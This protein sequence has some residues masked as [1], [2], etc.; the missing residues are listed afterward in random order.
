MGYVGTYTT[1]VPILNF[2]FQMQ[3]N[4]THEKGEPYLEQEVVS[5]NT[6]A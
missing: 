6:L 5:P 2:N 3:F 1:H 4:P